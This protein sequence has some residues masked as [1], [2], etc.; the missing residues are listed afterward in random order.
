MNEE[1]LPFRGTNFLV[2]AIDLLRKQRRELES[3][4]AKLQ[5]RLEIVERQNAAL[6]NVSADRL[7][8]KQV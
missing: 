1:D 8:Q 2:S 4:V 6:L 7:L 5:E 3:E